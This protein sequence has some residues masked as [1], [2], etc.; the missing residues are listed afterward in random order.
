MSEQE[1]DNTEETQDTTFNIGDYKSFIYKTLKYLFGMFV[2]L[3]IGFHVL[4]SCRHK[5]DDFINDYFPT[6]EKSY[7]FCHTINKDCNGSGYY[8]TNITVKKYVDGNVKWKTEP[9]N[10]QF[11]IDCVKKTTDNGK[12]I[13]QGTYD[14]EY[15]HWILYWW[16]NTFMKMN[17]Y[18]NEKFKYIYELIH[19]LID[20]NKPGIIDTCVVFFS[21]IL[22]K[23]MFIIIMPIVIIFMFFLGGCYAY[24]NHSWIL[25][26]PGLGGWFFIIKHFINGNMY[27]LGLSAFGSIIGWIFQPLI[28]FI[29]LCTL[30]LP[31][32]KFIR[33][34]VWNALT[35]IFYICL[36]I[37]EKASN[38]IN[39]T[40]KSDISS[41]HKYGK[42][43]SY[44]SEFMTGIFIIVSI[45]VL[46]F[47]YTYL[48]KG[49]AIGMTICCFYLIYIYSH[50]NK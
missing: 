15:I 41:D 42:M 25:T 11:N 4:Y 49:I 36:L 17:I 38:A 45:I 31:I 19:N 47:A 7:P 28:I 3:T 37:D 23:I 35:M 26:F 46:T 27:Q 5:F 13:L 10:P 16:N 48:T 34:Y 2:L 29:G 43:V 14:E 44:F 24:D 18:T 6:D 32:Y 50:S 39:G 1:T 9:Y 40:T 22:M 20:V 33:I 30:L 21:W 8:S 12:T